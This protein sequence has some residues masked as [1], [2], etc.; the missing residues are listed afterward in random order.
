MG[1]GNDVKS[2]HASQSGGTLGTRV[3]LPATACPVA[4]NW[5]TLFT[6]SGGL[7]LMTMLIGERI[8]VQA[9]GASNLS[10]RINATVG[11]VVAFCAA[12]VI[13][14]DAIGTLYTF[15]GN[16]NDACFA[17]FAGEAGMAGGLL[18]TGINT[19]GWVVPPGTVQ[20]NEDAATGTGSVQWTM[21]Y[22]PIDPEAHV[23]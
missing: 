2:L 9:G 6:V 16:P 18:A 8:A 11:G 23:V 19:H 22:V 5:T 3:F 17:G 1:L 13:D 12:T 21:R 14:A 10:I 4:A 15:T 7:I 20:W